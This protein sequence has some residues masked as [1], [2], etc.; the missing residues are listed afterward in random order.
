MATKQTN[1]C[2]ALDLT[3][4]IEILDVLEQ[5]APHICIL[6][7]H[8]DI[9][10]DFNDNL[11][12]NIAKL[13]EKHN[14]MIMEDRKFSDIGNTVMLQYTAGLHRIGSWA[15]L[16]TVHG[17]SGP[18]VIDS[19]RAGMKANAWENKGLFLLAEMSSKV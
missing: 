16:V 17:I 3:K 9:I 12:K 18:G 6:K 19:L 4:S 11:I 1:L 10:I 8:C 7:L 14:F 15:D 13:A 2:V 5:V